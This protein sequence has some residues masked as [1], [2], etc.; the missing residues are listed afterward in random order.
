MNV[1]Y[2]EVVDIRIEDG[3]QVGTV[4]VSG[5]LKKVPLELVE[6][7]QSGDAILMCDGVAIAR[8]E[9]TGSPDGRTDSFVI[10]HSDFVI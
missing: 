8:V 5:A 4:R 7:A 10:R 1:V 3:M 2:G 9:K 6:G